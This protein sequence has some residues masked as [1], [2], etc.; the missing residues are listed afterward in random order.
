MIN[1]PKCGHE[2]PDRQ[3]VCVVCGALTP[4][5]HFFYSEEKKWQPSKKMKIYA[6]VS[7]GI[8]LIL[9]ILNSL[10]IT[11]P[12]VIADK[13]YGAMSQ[14]F[15]SDAEKYTSEQYKNELSNNTSDMMAV[16]DDIYTE[17]SSDKLTYKTDAPI[18]DSDSDPKSARVKITLFKEDG[19][20][21]RQFTIIFVKEGRRWLVASLA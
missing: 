6:G 20:M 17:V 13:W 2:L 7:A 1:C 15:I 4:A 10:R 12:D 8:I 11:P 16:A 3:K 5:S 18:Y 19:S 14:R 21:S 9:L